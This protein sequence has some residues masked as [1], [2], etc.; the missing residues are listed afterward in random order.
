MRALE[1]RAPAAATSVPPASEPLAADV[2]TCQ[3]HVRG[4]FRF[5]RCLGA[6]CDEADELTQEAFVI[7]WQK[8]KQD[9]PPAALGAFL[10][11]AARLAWLEHRRHRRGEEV[12]L[13]T[14]TLHWWET[15][16]VDDGE[17]DVDA[18]RTCVQL[19]GPRAA[20]AVELA[21]RDGASRAAIAAQ[22]GMQPNGVKTLM[23]R[24]RAWLERC[25]RRQR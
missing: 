1:V 15:V 21:Y 22:L 10:R 25:I 5:L 8:G 17:G 14:L 24:T 16:L 23:A 3:R 12:A 11:R 7:A 4:V 6:S 20:R 2:D 18:A 9:L 19:L 13:A